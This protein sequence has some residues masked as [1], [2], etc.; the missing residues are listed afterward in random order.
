MSK[1]SKSLAVIAF[2]WGLLSE[3]LL[4]FGPVTWIGS[5]LFKLCNEQ[6]E[7]MP[8]FLRHSFQGYVDI[9]GIHLFSLLSPLPFVL[10]ICGYLLLEKVPRQLDR[11]VLVSVLAY[12]L[13]FTAGSGVGIL[14]LALYIAQSLSGLGNMG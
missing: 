8:G 1:M 13:A 4:F 10:L 5:A 7:N 11:S 9:D 14:V 12:L 2:F 6:C 3:P